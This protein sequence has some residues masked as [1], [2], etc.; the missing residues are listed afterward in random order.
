[1]YVKFYH[2]YHY[3]LYS[4]TFTTD[5]NPKSNCTGNGECSE[6]G[7]CICISGFRGENCS[8]PILPPVTCNLTASAVPRIGANWTVDYVNHQLYD[9]FIT[10]FGNES[11]TSVSIFLFNLTISQ[12][13]NLAKQNISYMTEE[14]NI[15]Q[16]YRV[17]NFYKLDP[18]QS[19]VGAG[20]VVVGD[21]TPVITQSS[22][23]NLTGLWIN[24]NINSFVLLTTCSCL[25]SRLL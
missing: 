23:S 13:W 2:L 4:F 7:E 25:E 14:G 1:M 20:F 3:Y 5:C 21:D 12:S 10:N 8:F 22:C 11:V 19:Y 15:V 9:M 6:T 18:L 17:L 16:E 24:F